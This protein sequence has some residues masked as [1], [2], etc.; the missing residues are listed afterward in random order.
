MDIY[1]PIVLSVPIDSQYNNTNI[2]YMLSL[3]YNNKLSGVLDYQRVF[4][5]KALVINGSVTLRLDSIL[6]NYVHNAKYDYNQ[7]EF[8]L[9]YEYTDFSNS[10]IPVETEYKEIMN[11]QIRIDFFYESIQRQI[12][13]SVYVDVNNVNYNGLSPLY[14]STEGLIH[15]GTDM[16]QHIPYS[17]TDKYYV[18]LTFARDKWYDGD[19]ATAAISS[20]GIEPIKLPLAYVGN[21]SLNIPLKTLYDELSQRAGTITAF[22][23]EDVSD[24]IY[25]GDAANPS[26]IEYIP[27]GADYSNIERE[28]ADSGKHIYL[29]EMDSDGELI[30][31]KEVAVVDECPNDWYVEFWTEKGWFSQPVKVSKNNKCT[32][33]SIVDIFNLNRRVKTI[34]NNSYTVTTNRFNIKEADAFSSI[35]QAG[36]VILYNAKEDEAIYCNIDTTTLNIN[37]KQGNIFNFT[38]TEIINR[39]Y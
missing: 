28:F 24:A 27:V 19:Y 5:G 11:T 20:N 38:L 26:P 3:A 30:K 21:Y 9:K 32:F 37:R 14:T 25:G 6:L 39:E 23:G 16:V 10:I 18:G 36:F 12:R 31:K 1:K 29:S 15:Y 8:K 13:Q 7:Q 22:Y 17:Y 33:K 35:L 4:V 34:N 2:N